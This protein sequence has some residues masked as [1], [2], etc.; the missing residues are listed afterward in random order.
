MET[1]PLYAFNNFPID[2]APWRFFIRHPRWPGLWSGQS[3]THLD[4]YIPLLPAEMITRAVVLDCSSLQFQREASKQADG[5]GGAPC[6]HL[7]H[8]RND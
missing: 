3:T 7:V 5:D 4:H 8:I 6:P 1:L 2:R